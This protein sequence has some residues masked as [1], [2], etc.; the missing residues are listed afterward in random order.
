[1][2]R[3][4]SVAALATAFAVGGPW[5]LTRPAAPG[6]TLVQ[7]A[8][9]PGAAQAQEAGDTAIDTGTV[10]EMA[11]GAI[12]A[13]VTLIE[14]A[15]FTCPHCA[16]FHAEQYPQLKPYIEDGRVR[17]IFREVYF[18]RFGLW[19]SIVA[20]CAGDTMRFFGI[21][22]V[23]YMTQREWIGD[24]EPATIADNLRTIGLTA[25]LEPAALDACFADETKARTLIAWY[26]ENAARDNVSATPSFMVNGT[27]YPN[28]TFAEMAAI[29]DP[30]VAASDWTAP[31]E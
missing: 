20:R 19:A 25:G 28:M 12:D 4:L 17:L 26:E 2:T 21:T 10:P 27:L 5:M 16:N 1:M 8:I 9:Q 15:S 31:T 13:P 11:Q 7:D 18:D 30:I 3:H 14:Y 22:D 29:I 6:Q 24:G 23:L